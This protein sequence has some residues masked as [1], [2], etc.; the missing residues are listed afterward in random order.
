MFDKT[1]VIL[2]RPRAFKKNINT[3]NVESNE[4]TK[5]SGMVL[6]YADWCGHCHNISPL[7]KLLAKNAE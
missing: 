3:I 7:W 4:T 6:M 5:K 2:L 1:S